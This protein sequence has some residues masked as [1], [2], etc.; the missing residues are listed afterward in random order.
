M[1]YIAEAIVAHWGEK[2]PDYDPGCFAC[3]AWK[4]YED[5]KAKAANMDYKNI[6]EHYIAHVDGFEGN[7]Y[8]DYWSPVYG[9]SDEENA[10]LVRLSSERKLRL[11]ESTQNEVML[12]AMKIKHYSASPDYRNLRIVPISTHTKP[13]PGLKR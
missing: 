1:S 9:L 10:E 8:I 13:A 5:L 3:L 11:E 7:D 4:E 2:C 12:K 6:L